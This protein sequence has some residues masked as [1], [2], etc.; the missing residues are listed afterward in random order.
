MHRIQLISLWLVFVFVLIWKMVSG[1]DMMD[2]AFNILY[3]SEG[4]MEAY[5]LS[6]LAVSFG[7]L[8]SNWVGTKMIEFRFLSG[9]LLCLRV[10]MIGLA[11]RYLFRD[12]KAF[13]YSLVAASL[14]LV[15]LWAPWPGYD[16]F[17]DLIITAILVA[18]LVFPRP[19]AAYFWVVF[20]FL[21]FL[22]IGFRIP[23]VA[24]L[25]IVA[26]FMLLD[27]YFSEN[28]WAAVGKK[29]FGLLVGFALP[30][31]LFSLL[32]YADFIV[33]IPTQIGVAGSGNTHNMMTLLTYYLNDLGDLLL[34][35]GFI[36]GVLFL[37]ELL[38]SRLGK[39]LKWIIPVAIIS[40]TGFLLARNDQERF[41]DPLYSLPGGICISL[42]LLW[43]K[44]KSIRPQLFW[45]FAITALLFTPAIGSNTG[46]L[47]IASHFTLMIPF[48]FMLIYRT[49]SEQ[50][51]EMDT[52][53]LPDKLG[54]IVMIPLVLIG[55]LIG[56]THS[57]GDTRVFYKRKHKV[58]VPLLSGVMTTESRAQ[59]IESVYKESQVRKPNEPLVFLGM[60][61]HFF[62][63]ISEVPEYLMLP[64]WFDLGQSSVQEALE[65]GLAQEELSSATIIYI[66]G[67]PMV[68]G[69]QWPGV[70][71][72]GDWRN[73]TETMQLNEILERNGFIGEYKE[74]WI[75]FR[76][77]REA[78]E[79]DNV[80]VAIP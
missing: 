25:F 8:W 31:G 60:T 32:G 74:S 14:M 17:S 36:L 21:M 61:R 52:L 51:I 26:L 16:A 22:A 53:T 27:D 24:G 28:S 57:F 30:V 7:N 40:F 38:T 62:R 13:Q 3:L 33:G 63:Y 80:G 20:G 12:E 43:L 73:F 42:S 47:R 39:G 11:G 59:F 55:I 69:S 1:I 37:P 70:L 46:L 15:G 79:K 75:V 41:L 54:K 18:L 23:D 45:V 77:K 66:P 35:S 64:F 56:L 2:T 44:T 71:A 76:K 72:S 65:S 48:L 67:N 19:Y 4:E 50:S 78:L 6:P 68:M 34:F 9:L 58:D 10:G 5:P 49:N 29:M